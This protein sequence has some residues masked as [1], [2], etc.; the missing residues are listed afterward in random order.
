M[1]GALGAF[2]TKID[3]G[4]LIG[5]YGSK[6]HRELI[7]V[8]DIRNKFAHALDVG[9]FY[10][11]PIKD[12]AFNLSFC[13]RYAADIEVAKADP[14]NS[15]RDE[16]AAMPPKDWPNWVFVQDLAGALKDPKERYIVTLQVMMYAFS[17]PA[18][19][20]MPEGVF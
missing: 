11:S 4:Y 20:A 7:T 18:G 15:K 12:L 14:K 16:F 17:I 6:A 8:K 3:L 2:S 13:E 5:L 9:S 19:M 1:T 10:N